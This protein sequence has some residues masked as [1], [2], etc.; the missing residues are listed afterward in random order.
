VRATTVPDLRFSLVESSDIAT[1][2][3]SHSATCSVVL[4]HSTFTVPCKSPQLCQLEVCLGCLNQACRQRSNIQ[5]R[6]RSPTDYHGFTN[7]KFCNSQQDFMNSE[8]SGG[9]IPRFRIIQNH[10]D[11]GAC[12]QIIRSSYHKLGILDHWSYMLVVSFKTSW[13]VTELCKLDVLWIH[14]WITTDLN[15]GWILVSPICHRPTII[16][17]THCVSQLD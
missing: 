3:H 10:S 1:L 8:N 15:P 12:T 14:Q 13:N 6:C 2:R 11:H 5:V 7:A 9:I 16:C 17:V 4:L